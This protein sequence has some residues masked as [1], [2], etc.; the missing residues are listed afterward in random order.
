M[1]VVDGYCL[2]KNDIYH[3]KDYFDKLSNKST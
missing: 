3:L 2:A 1:I